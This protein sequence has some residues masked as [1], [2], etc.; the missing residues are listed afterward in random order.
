MPPVPSTRH[1]KDALPQDWV[2]AKVKGTPIG[3][4]GTV[5]EVAPSV[6]LLASDAGAFYVGACLNMNGGDHMA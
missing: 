2:N 4:F 6:L 1:H 3:R 5:E